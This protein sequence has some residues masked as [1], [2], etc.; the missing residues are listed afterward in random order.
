MLYPIKLYKYKR[1]NKNKTHFDMQI[2][3]IKDI[4]IMTF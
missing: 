2:K 1:K 4:K 3:E